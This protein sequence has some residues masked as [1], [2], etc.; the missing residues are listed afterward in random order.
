[1]PVLYQL[2]AAAAAMNRLWNTVAFR[3]A[4]GYGLW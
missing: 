1:M 4:I 2:I 3:L